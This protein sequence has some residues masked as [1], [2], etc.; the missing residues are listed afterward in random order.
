MN[1][2][3]TNP[4][5]RHHWHTSN[6][7]ILQAQTATNNQHKEQTKKVNMFPPLDKFIHLSNN[8]QLSG[9]KHR[10]N[11]VHFIRQSLWWIFKQPCILT[12]S[13]EHKDTSINILHKW[14]QTKKHF[15]EKTADAVHTL[16]WLLCVMCTQAS[17]H[18]NCVNCII[19]TAPQTRMH[20]HAKIC[21]HACTRAH[22][23]RHSHMQKN[24]H[25][26]TGTQLHTKYMLHTQRHAQSRTIQTHMITHR[27]AHTRRYTQ[28]CKT[29]VQHVKA[30]ASGNGV[31]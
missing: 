19:C 8:I 22:T 30:H 29:C 17:T 3:K 23:Q 7:S 25:T 5:K 12:T 15:S 16:L 27:D 10:V 20:N 26:C 24:T 31:E 6:A 18:T 4:T 21:A 1:T 11:Y 2:F 13:H 9:L 14:M 28:A